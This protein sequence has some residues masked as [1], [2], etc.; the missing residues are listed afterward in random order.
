MAAMRDT[1]GSG[2]ELDEALVRVGR[3]LRR[4][5]VSADLRTLQKSGG[6]EADRFYR[7]RWSYD[8]VVRRPFTP[9]GSGRPPTPSSTRP[10]APSR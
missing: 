8:K 5:T 7:D 10:T 9:C 4:G 2:S 6:Q 3:H 1:P